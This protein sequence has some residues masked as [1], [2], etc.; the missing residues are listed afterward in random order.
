MFTKPTLFVVGAGGSR[1]L[2]LPIG[3]ELKGQIASK[4]NLT[5]RD[6]YTRSSGEGKIYAA[7]ENYLQNSGLRDGNP[8][9]QAGRSI[10]S[11]MPQAISID[12]YLHAHYDDE[13][14][15]LM[16]K[17]G[18][19]AS[20]L[21]A[22]RASLIF[23]D[24][25]QNER[26]DFARSANTWHNVFCKML[27]ENVQKR[28]LE[29][30]F[31][32]I[33]FITFNYDRCIEHYLA[34]WLQNYML[35]SAEEAQQLVNGV[36][37]VHPYGQIGQLPWQTKRII[38]VRYGAEVEAQNLMDIASNI[39]T[40][41]EQVEDEMIPMQM[42]RLM[43]DAEQLVYLGFSF[44][45]MNMDLLKLEETGLLKKVIGT[46]FGI[47]APNL[48]VIKQRISEDLRVDNTTRLVS[49]DLENSHCYT[50]L[51]DY[52]RVLTG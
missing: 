1:E 51:S 8:Y 20:I 39:R 23:A 13:K 32:N 28:D 5:F 9:W 4:V 33:A 30:V 21:E 17:L 16:G 11:A 14:I 22:E 42:K 47:S 27:T 41:T 7:I 46:A 50:L 3:D 48:H 6:A 18:I 12:N 31:R 2:N 29:R 24:D 52:Y 34:I 19:A 45:S 37:I 15:V 10:A 35:I 26:H 38:P 44:G 36:T 40:F 49:Q 25:R 43:R